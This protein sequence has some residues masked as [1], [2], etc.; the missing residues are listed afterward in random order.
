M[1]FRTAKLVSIAK[2]SSK[3]V[4]AG[5]MFPV[6]TV[7]MATLIIP[8][9]FVQSP[10]QVNG[11]DVATAEEAILEIACLVISPGLA[12]NPRVMTQ[13]TTDRRGVPT[14]SRA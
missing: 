8:N 7:Y 3:L 14:A 1:E 9:N 5:K 11:R 10:V 6:M 12:A 2:S 13:K 4:H